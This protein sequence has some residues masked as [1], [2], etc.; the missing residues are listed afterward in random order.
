MNVSTANTKNNIKTILK[1][2]ARIFTGKRIQYIM[3]LSVVIASSFLAYVYTIASRRL[4]V[5]LF[6]NCN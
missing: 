6:F 5:N 3:F 4:T 2:F 1:N